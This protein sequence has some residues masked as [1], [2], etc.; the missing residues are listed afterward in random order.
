MS[1]GGAGSLG[2]NRQGEIPCTRCEGTRLDPE[3][4]RECPFE[5]VDRATWEVL[6]MAAHAKMGRW[7][8][9]GGVLDQTQIFFDACKEIWTA[10]AQL[11]RATL[12]PQE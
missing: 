3:P 12:S 9:A 10:Q 7:P 4:M 8:I 11:S 1:C 6:D 2:F 5:F